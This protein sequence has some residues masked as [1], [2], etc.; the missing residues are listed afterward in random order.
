ML[1]RPAPPPPQHKPWL[2]EVN[3]G[4]DL[5]LF[6]ARLR[7]LGLGMLR[8]L[9]R[10]LE[11]EDI[12]HRSSP[13]PEAAEAEEAEAAEAA[14]GAEETEEAEGAEEAEE[15][16]EAEKVEET[17]LPSS[18]AVLGGFECVLAQR[19]AAPAGELERFK[20]LL[21]LAGCFAHSLHEASGAPVRGVQGLVRRSAEQQ[22]TRSGSST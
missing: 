2:L 18:G 22:A 4:P 3:S 17:R 10:V 1:C 9:L 13:R 5:S 15:A 7:P 8:G 20:R 11:S 16:N 6:G 14:K 12:F 19:C 21:S